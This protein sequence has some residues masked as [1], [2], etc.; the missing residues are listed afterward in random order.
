MHN[1]CMQP[2]RSKP[3]SG[4][5]LE[6]MAKPVRANANRSCCLSF[7]QLPVVHVERFDHSR[8]RLA[9]VLYETVRPLRVEI[10][11]PSFT[12]DVRF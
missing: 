8:H 2:C 6:V 7:C 4:V 11:T 10:P 9:P 3:H 12:K 1:F 5:P